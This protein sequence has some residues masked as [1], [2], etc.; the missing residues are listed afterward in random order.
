MYKVCH[1][2]SVHQPEDG[3]IF[4]R[5]CVSLA[6]AGYDTYL[7]ER[8]ESYDKDGVHI[9]GIGKPEKPGRLYR[10]TTFT[11]KAFEAA[12]KVD[13]D[14]YHLHDPELLQFARQLKK[15][16]KK[17]VFDSHENYVLMIKEK[18]YL[19]FPTLIAKWFERY[20]NKIF[21]EI[22]G[23]IYPNTGEYYTNLSKICK[24]ICV[25][26]N[27]PWKHELYDYYS[28]EIPKEKR[29]ACYIGT[30]TRGHGIIEIVKACYQAGYKLYLA[31]TFDTEDFKKEVLSLKEFSCVDF[32]G[33]IGRDKV[34]D[35]LQKVEVGLCV[36]HHIGQ[37]YPAGSLSTKVYECM[38]MAIPVILNNSPYNVNIIRKYG[39]GICVR[40]LEVSEI[41]KA[42]QEYA[43]NE[44]LRRDTGKRGQELFLNKFCWDQEQNNL[45]KM[46]EEIFEDNT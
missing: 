7:V 23:V 22:D 5:A 27:Y 26:G 13:A 33:V 11:K 42:L 2:T 21:S 19:P 18:K 34:L 10:M 20:S 30:L 16:G 17:V 32:L 43:V 4:R 35:I 41:A 38:A 29:T 14:L 9:I 46:Y 44:K 1:V 45:I 40:P 15:K 24:H 8:G 12:L 37:F 36:L 6:K 3:R 25:T 28:A 31:G 39:F